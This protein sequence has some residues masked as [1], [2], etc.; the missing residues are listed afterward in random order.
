[1]D[2][3]GVELKFGPRRSRTSPSRPSGNTRAARAACRPSWKETADGR[4]VRSALARG[5]QTVMRHHGKMRWAGKPKLVLSDGAQ[6]KSCA[7]RGREAVSPRPTGKRI[8]ENIQ[9]KPGRTFIPRFVPLKGIAEDGKAG[10]GTANHPTGCPGLS[11]LRLL[12]AVVLG[13][14]RATGS[15]TEQSDI[16]I[17]LCVVRTRRILPIQCHCGGWTTGAGRPLIC[18]EGG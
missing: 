9:Q 11:G 10:Y 17:G 8:H 7:A 1:M 3:D 15:A 13:G 18:T 4:D 16:D 5:R 6:P 2:L 12:R 14:S